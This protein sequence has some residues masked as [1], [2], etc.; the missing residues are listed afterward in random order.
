MSMKKL[1]YL[2]AFDSGCFQFPDL[3]LISTLRELGFNCQEEFLTEDFAALTSLRKLY[4]TRSKII[5][6]PEN[7]G[8]LTQLKTLYLRTCDIQSLPASLGSISTLTELEFRD[9]PLAKKIPP[10]ILRQSAKEIIRYIFQQ[11]SNAPKQFF[12]ESKT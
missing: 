7:I 3:F 2:N 1:I 6:L 10:E 9:T 11:Q 12:N 4:L 8:A 5:A